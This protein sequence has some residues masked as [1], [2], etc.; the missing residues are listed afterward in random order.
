MSVVQFVVDEAA[1]LGKL[2]PISDMIA[3]GRGYGIRLILIYQSLGQL[4]KCFPEGEDQTLQG[5]V[6]SIFFGVNDNATAEYVS[7][8]LGESTIVVSS[9]STSTGRSSSWSFGGQPQHGGGDS[10][11]ATASW[12]QQVR[13]LVKPEEV[14]TLP[15][16]TAITFMPGMPPIRTTLLRYYEEK[17][18]RRPPGWVGRSLAATFI[19]AASATLC[20]LA[21]GFAAALT[22]AAKDD[23][24]IREATPPAIRQWL[25][26]VENFSPNRSA[27]FKAF[28]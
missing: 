24:R 14:M 22:L 13:K 3:I 21:F 7:N 9:G 2:E 18:L 6:S 16:R 12:Q 5:N 27:L 20:V 23:P 19:L 4:K 10:D 8:R 28:E 25:D 15:P 1:S 26:S 17:W 11:N